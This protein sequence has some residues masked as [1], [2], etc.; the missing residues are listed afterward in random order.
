MF[1]IILWYLIISYLLFFALL[2]N[3]ESSS[4]SSADSEENMCFWDC[5]TSEDYEKFYIAG[6]L[7]LVKLDTEKLSNFYKECLEDSAEP[8]KMD[9]VG[10]TVAK[11]QLN[12]VEAQANKIIRDLA[13]TGDTLKDGQLARK[14]AM[15]TE[16][17]KLAKCAK[18]RL[19]L[20][21]CECEHLK[22][23]NKAN[24]E[25][26][27]TK[28]TA[29]KEDSKCNFD[30]KS[31]C[32][33]SSEK[34]DSNAEGTIDCHNQENVSEDEN[35]H[36]SLEN[37]FKYEDSENIFHF[38]SEDDLDFLESETDK[39]SKF[40]NDGCL[41]KCRH[42]EKM[43]SAEK[44]IVHLDL[45]FVKTKAKKLIQILACVPDEIL[46]C[47]ITLKTN[48]ITELEDLV[49]SARDTLRMLACE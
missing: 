37:F 3:S 40:H 26:E 36:F 9:R 25:I 7:D 31:T 30:G 43:S 23:Q 18:E 41:K 14:K 38:I 8:D 47:N 29:F 44:L 20:F 39:L 12:S 1:K 17:E 6:V 28:A 35:V 24:N 5:R 10:I 22:N 42:P 45:N 32:S 48:M 11:I 4:S 21:T 19:Q 34:Y 33:D 15:K 49:E 16:L 46:S 13:T 2:V 27:K